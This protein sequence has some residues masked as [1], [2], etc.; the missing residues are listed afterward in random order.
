MWT[1]E[2]QTGRMLDPD[3]T[4]VGVGYSGHVEGVNAPGFEMIADVGPIPAGLYTVEA[5]IDS[6]THG[7]FA[8]PLNPD[9][10]NQMFGRDDFLIHGDRVDAPGL[11]QA[12]LGCIIMARGVRED[13]WA[14]PDHQLQV[15]PILN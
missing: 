5:P 12:S 3:G 4:L 9:P 14:S 15:V 2:Q 1:Y 6:E 10:A 11:R 8:L 13:I 7:P